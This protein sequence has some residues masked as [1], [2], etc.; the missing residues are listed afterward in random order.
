MNIAVLDMYKGTPNE[1]MKGI[2][3]ILKEYKNS[4]NGETIRYQ[5]FDVRSTFE[6]PN[7]DFDAY[8]SSGGPGNPNFIEEEGNHIWGERW[9]QLMMNIM[10]YNAQK[11][12]SK[13][14]V[15]LICHSFQMMCILTKIAT[16]A[17]RHSPS[18]GIYPM[19]KTHEGEIEKNFIPLPDP[20]YAVD[21]RNYQVLNP[22]LEYMKSKNMKILAYE[23]S[24]PHISYDP[25]VMSVRFSN[26]I[27]GTQ[28]HP[29]ADPEN[30]KRL[31]LTTTK[32]DEV[33]KEHS[34]AKYVDI[35]NS[36][37]NPERITK[38]FENILPFFL[39]QVFMNHH[40]ESLN[41]KEVSNIPEQTTLI[42][43]NTDRL[44]SSL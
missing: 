13:K 15:F 34:E 1:G 12:N 18:F 4:V 9:N 26:E 30:L 22:D 44:I 41:R 14:S 42:K 40:Q 5:V 31:F 36:I 35:L 19:F 20:F 32:K 8:I 6:L 28:F 33:I 43:K 21:S 2:H 17:L 7:L 24:R 16:V 23:K 27:I 38:T 29:E 11:T 10:D 3:K 39:D 37:E 25:A